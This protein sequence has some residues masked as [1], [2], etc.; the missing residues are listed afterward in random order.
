VCYRLG[1]QTTVGSGSSW[2][3]EMFVIQSAFERLDHFARQEA[4]TFLERRYR[5]SANESPRSPRAE[6][7]PQVPEPKNPQAPKRSG[8]SSGGA[9]YGVNAWLILECLE[10]GPA[11]PK[12]IE[13]RTGVAHAPQYLKRLKASGHVRS[14]T[15]GFYHFVSYPN[16]PR[17]T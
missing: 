1:M 2:G 6:A 17:P 14:E 12:V 11:S 10:H 9:P 4:L 15:R 5:H 13:E 8:G 16:G 7:L 3:E